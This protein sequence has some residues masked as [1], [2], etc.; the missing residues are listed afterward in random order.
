MGIF[1]SGQGKYEWN[2]AKYECLLGQGHEKNGTQ[3]NVEWAR[4]F[5][6]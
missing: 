6:D 5:I 3:Q 2:P 4:L 1:V